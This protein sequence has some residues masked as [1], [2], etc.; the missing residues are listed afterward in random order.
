MAASGRLRVLISGGGGMLGSALCASIGRPSAANFFRPA[1]GRLLRAGSTPLGEHDV[2]W[3]PYEMRVDMKRLE[4][5]DA[6]VHL[7][8]W[9]GVGRGAARTRTLFG[10]P[11]LP[12]TRPAA[13]SLTTCR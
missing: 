4:D 11:P 6:V 7:A 8:G 9:C 2:F 13:R 12:R 5:F 1:V 3:D 10:H